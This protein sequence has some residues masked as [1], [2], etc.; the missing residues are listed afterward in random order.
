MKDCNKGPSVSYRSYYYNC[1]LFV[2]VLPKMAGATSSNREPVLGPALLY[3]SCRVH[4]S[5]DG[6]RN[7]TSARCEAPHCHV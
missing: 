7:S 3:P 6:V 2:V 1:V 4:S 5:D